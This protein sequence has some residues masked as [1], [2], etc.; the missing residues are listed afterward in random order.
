MNKFMYIMRESALA[1]FLIPAGIIF[2]V[3]GIIFFFAINNSQNYV[4]TTSTI[5]NVTLV[6]DAYTDTDGNRVEATYD[7]EV[8]YVVDGQEYKSTLPGMGKRNIGEKMKIYYNPDDPSQITQSKSFIIP[9]VMV[10]G[11]IA[12]LVGGIISAKNAINRYK[13]MKEQEKGWANE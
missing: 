7:I 8:K 13:K 9:I 2:I 5:S 10:V 4:E 6:E 11:G 3:V 1:R 12:S